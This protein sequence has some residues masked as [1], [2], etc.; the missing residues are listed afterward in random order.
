MERPTPVSSLLHSSTIVVARVYLIM[1]MTVKMNTMVIVVLLLSMNM[2]GHF[3]VKKNIAY[4]TS[5]H[6]LVM[7]IL[8]IREIYHAVVVYIILHRIVKR[9]IFQ[10]S[11]YGIHGIR[12]QDIRRYVINSG[13]YII[14]MRIV[15]LSAIMRI[16]IIAAKELVVLG[17]VRVIILFLVLIS[18]MYTISYVNK[19]ELGNLTREVERFYVLILMLCS[20]SVLA[21]NFSFWVRFLVIRLGVMYWMGNPMTTIV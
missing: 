19:C 11:G 20:L 16:V 1:L 5:I 2:V 10:S 3:D 13:T 9:Q 6:L 4:S 15:F 14:I 8:S 7:L 12:S 21:V 18:Y 17:I